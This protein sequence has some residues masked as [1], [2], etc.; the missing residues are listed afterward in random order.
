MTG[1]GVARTLAAPGT[2]VA[3]PASGFRAAPRGCHDL[4]GRAVIHGCPQNRTA[5]DAEPQRYYV[6][7]AVGLQQRM[8]NEY[9]TCPG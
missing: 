3:L 7:A 8:Q 2:R 6:P 9:E 4:S 1:C 5:G